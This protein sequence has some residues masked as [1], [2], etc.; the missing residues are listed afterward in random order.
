MKHTIA[1]ALAL[2]LL[3]AP[4]CSAA[5][6]SNSPLES[7][8]FPEVLVTAPAESM[9]VGTATG[10][11][12]I[13]A[14]PAELPLSVDVIPQ[15]LLQQREVTSVYHA[16]EQVAGVFTEGKSSFTVSAGKPNIRGFGGNDVLLDGL[17]LPSIMPI[18]MD[19]ASLSGVEIYKGP[20][21]SVQGGQSGLEGSGGGIYLLAKKP[22]FDHS[23]VRLS[24]AST[25]GNGESL[26]FLGDPNQIL[27]DTLA[28]RVPLALTG[29]HPYY[30]P[31]RIDGNWT[32]AIAPGMAWKPGE[33]TTLTLAASW[34]ETERAMYQGIPYIK[35]SF[36]VPRDTYYG[37]DDT[38]IDYSGLTAQVRLDHHFR[39]SL[40]LAIGGGY[41]R[42]D[43]QR[44]HWSVSPNPRPQ[45]AMSVARYY[46]TILAT[47]TARFNHSD[48]D[49]LSENIAAFAHLAHDVETGH[50]AHQLLLGTDW[51]RRETSGKSAF[52][53]TDWMSIDSP[54]LALSSPMPRPTQSHSQT[55]RIGLLFQD[56]ATWKQ[57]RVLVGGRADYTDSQAGNHAWSYSPR[58]GLTCFVRPEIALF[59]NATLAEGPNFG[60]NDINGRELDKPWRSEQFEAGAKM[61]FF[62]NLWLTLSAFQITQKN[63]PQTDP[64]DPTLAS[65]VLDGENRSRGIE[66]SLAGELT[67][68]WT[69]W[70]SYTW[71]EYE[72]LDADIQFER[73]PAH[74][75]VLWTAYRIPGGPLKGLQAGIGLR[76]R[77]K[78]YTTFRAGWLGEE[79]KINPS[80]VVDIACDYPLPWAAAQRRDLR[81][82][83]GVKNLFDKEYV[84]SNRHGTENFPGQP[85]TG[86]VRLN[87]AF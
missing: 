56:F 57:W 28:I 64:R 2:A 13:S 31:G 68:D 5:Q 54:T 86:W 79:Y 34:T 81:L 39:D 40:R 80:T 6:S 76:A 29:E 50:V 14:H 36:L 69:W 38:R 65:Y 26:R 23:F 16:L 55:D 47:R 53:T 27:T 87:A 52:A 67:P 1:T 77:S 44:K 35:G 62:D 72:D 43:E 78:S 41:A 58:M 46:D 4:M 74:S 33:K 25:F 3:A 48:S 19:A 45:D 17:T 9:H 51:L 85:I 66:A 42:A 37:T 21:S 59:A 11:T 60:Y 12:L 83:F 8:T 10:G 70:G 32:A 61:N 15:T 71:C 18:Y 75:A 24:L 7:V 30:L 22:E 84:E 63:I 73:F 49:N 20:I 82:A